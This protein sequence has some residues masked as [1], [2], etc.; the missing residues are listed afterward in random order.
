M[1]EQMRAPVAATALDPALQMSSTFETKDHNVRNFLQRAYAIDN[2]TWSKTSPVGTVLKTYRFPD[3]LLSQPA[4]AAKTRNFFGLRAGVEFMVLVNKQQFQAGNLLVSYLPNAKYNPAKAAMAQTSLPTLT[5]MPRT[6]LDLMDATKATLQ[7]PYASP[8]VYY[9]LLTGAGTIG[10]F[11]ITVYSPIT[12]VADGGTVSVQVFARFVDIDL[13]FPTGS[14]PTPFTKT[15]AIDNLIEKFRVS[16]SLTT[17]NSVLKEGKDILDL[18]K[19]GRFRFQMNSE[20]ITTMNFKPRALPNMAV[21]SDTNNAHIMSLSSSNVLPSTNMGETS[22]NEMNINTVLQIPCYHDSFTV[23]NEA[24]GINVWSKL[25]QPQVPI[26]P[27]TDGSLNVDYI[28]FHAEPFSKWRGSLLYNFRVVKTTF[29]SLRV[30]VWFSPA[31][32][33]SDTIDRNAVYSKIV[34][35]K[36]TN[37]FDFQVP[38]VWPHPFLNV[39]VNPMS[40]GTIGVDIVN[41]MVFPATVADNINFIV[42]RSAGT[43]F[44]LNLPTVISA[45]PFDPTEIT[46]ALT[47]NIGSHHIRARKGVQLP[48]PDSVPSYDVAGNSDYPSSVTATN[49]YSRYTHMPREMLEF[50]NSNRTTI[51]LEKVQL[52]DDLARVEPLTNAF[53]KLDVNVLK[54]RLKNLYSPMRREDL[55]R[56]RQAGFSSQWIRDLTREGIESNPGPTFSTFVKIEGSTFPRVDFFPDVFVVGDRV[57]GQLT[58]MVAGPAQTSGN[59]DATLTGMPGV[60]NYN[61]LIS[62][63]D[64]STYTVNIDW[65]MSD[66]T[67]VASFDGTIIGGGPIS[68]IVSLVYEL[69]PPNPSLDISP[70]PLPVSIDAQ[71]TPVAV[72]FGQPI[73]VNSTI[74]NPLPLPVSVNA[75]SAPVAVSF[76][77]PISVNSTVVNPLPLPVSI[78][79]QSTPV[80][81]TLDQIVS[82]DAN[83]VNPV[84]LP[85]TTSGGG[86]SGLVASTSDGG[87]SIVATTSTAP[88]CMPFSFQM[89]AEQD[90]LRT[91]YDDTTFHRPVQSTRA[92]S[93]ILG[94]KVVDVRDMIKRSSLFGSLTSP[95]IAD[96]I[97]TIVPHMIGDVQ[98]DEDGLVHQ[99]ACDLISYYASTYAFARGGVNLRI[100]TAPDFYWNTILDP[101][102]T[103]YTSG[104]SIGAIAQNAA[105][106]T[107]KQ[108]FQLKNPLQQ[109][110]KPSLEGFGEVSVPFYSDTFMYSINPTQIVEPPIDNQQLQL[111]YTQLALLPNGAYS[112]FQVFRAACS[113]FEF[114]YLTGPPKLFPIS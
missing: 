34:D 17:L 22:S 35:L 60:Q 52:L 1:E 102:S 63:G 85:V 100:I 5:G 87:C 64:F 103:F 66:T 32:S 56:K 15:P 92:D 82:V 108:L 97:I 88:F 6:N 78:N 18:V 61:I 10:D 43:D 80:A 71:S 14:V 111:P 62:G 67:I 91:G 77:Q 101:D 45:F 83:I 47:A 99:N 38:F 84:P 41:A 55:R 19:D 26:T 57:K 2:F 31:S 13:E 48:L 95:S 21:S 53:F 107:A 65:I 24:S 96:N 39:H 46:E 30:R 89:N 51:P 81:V 58:M 74:V 109:V 42:E 16:P 40:L 54:N 9:N 105:A 29:H 75:Q 86:G 112:Q 50:A 20:N 59:L 7:V 27:N 114:S 93:L 113:D 33:I 23:S 11:Y 25:V 37:Q 72:T 106:P 98:K 3:I 104:E 68:C 49:D 70:L 4:L 110:V 12:D 69:N 28:H 76:D 79:A 36:D 94:Q 73:S 44:C 90:S 8:Y